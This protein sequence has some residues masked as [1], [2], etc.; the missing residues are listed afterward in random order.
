MRREGG[1]RKPMS[2][3]LI[4]IVTVGVAIAGL[5]LTS[6]RS[7]RS[8]M[9]KQR[10]ELRSEMAKQRD[11][12]RSE[13]AKQR[14]ELRSEMAKQRDGMAAL[15]DELT[16][17]LRSLSERVAKLEGLLEGLREAFAPATAVGRAE[18]R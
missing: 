17:E 8:E 2:G 1:V 9:A 5:I 15:R 6:F 13:M 4:A 7:L 16:R 12:L 11:E 18:R 3:E 10:D 14:D